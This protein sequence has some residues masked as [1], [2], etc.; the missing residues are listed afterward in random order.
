MFEQV[1]VNQ[2][3]TVFMDWA[4]RICIAVFYVYVG[5]VKFSNAPGSEWV[6]IF[7][8]IGFGQWFRIFTGVVEVLGGVLVLIPWTVTAGLA[9]LACTMLGA[10]LTAAFVI[11]SPLF[12]IFPGAF[13]IG[14]VAA[15]LNR[16][17]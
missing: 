15:Y 8:K 2:R 5:A 6:K 13:L 11:G 14:L 12:C 1:A 17:S 4:V 9:L 3:R 10:I 7:Q 16:R